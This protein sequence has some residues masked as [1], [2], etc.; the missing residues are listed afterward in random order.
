MLWDGFGS[1]AVC[2][3]EA[4]G[5]C[6]GQIVAAR[7]GKCFEDTDR[8][9]TN[10]NMMMMLMLVMCRRSCQHRIHTC[11]HWAST[12]AGMDR[13]R[14]LQQRSHCANNRVYLSKIMRRRPKGLEVIVQD[15]SLCAV[16]MRSIPL[17][18]IQAGGATPERDA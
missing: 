5:A 12:I 13:Q 8:I 10:I 3:D 4:I 16:Q 1:F 18:Q 11:S 15:D 7:G 2:A 6:L 9:I 14:G 17:V